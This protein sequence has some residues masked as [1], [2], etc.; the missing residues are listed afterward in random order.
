MWFCRGGPHCGCVTRHVPWPGC[1]SIGIGQHSGASRQV[2]SGEVMWVKWESMCDKQV[3]LRVLFQGRG[4]GLI[5]CRCRVTSLKTHD[6]WQYYSVRKGKNSIHCCVPEDM[7]HMTV[8]L[9]CVS[10]RKGS[11]DVGTNLSSEGKELRSVTGNLEPIY[12]FL[13]WQVCS[14]G[15]EICDKKGDLRLITSTPVGDLDLY[16]QVNS[17]SKPI[18]GSVQVSGTGYPD[19]QVKYL[20]THKYS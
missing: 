10:L 14:S 3:W 17:N 15:R 1:I 2:L 8:L 12:V 20:W 18:P 16:L 6:T 4:P 19:S 9:I 11:E 5:I 7:W 13:V